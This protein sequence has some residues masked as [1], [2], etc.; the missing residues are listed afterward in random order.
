MRRRRRRRRVRRRRD[1]TKILQPQHRGWGTKFFQPCFRMHV[2]FA[3][4]IALSLAVC[5]SL[6]LRA[7]SLLDADLV[8]SDDPWSPSLA[9]VTFVVRIYGGWICSP[10]VLLG[11][12]GAAVQY[13]SAFVTKRLVFATPEFQKDCKQL[14]WLLLLLA[15]RARDEQRP[16]NW[17]FLP[18]AQ[19]WAAEKAK[20][21]H[22]KNP[23]PNEVLSCL[24]NKQ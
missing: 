18:S 19:Q 3:W 4:W 7:S 13:V 5:T 14:W 16:M 22:A 24:N 12:P 15:K 6:K 11:Q 10:K 21:K 8:L 23:R 17:K 9:L 20:R 1:N 2:S